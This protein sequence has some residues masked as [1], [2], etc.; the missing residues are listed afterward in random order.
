MFSL[1]GFLCTTLVAAC[2]LAWCAE[3][4]GLG[5][6]GVVRAVVQGDAIKRRLEIGRAHV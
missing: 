1:L 6:W 5:D 4:R 3:R 2:G